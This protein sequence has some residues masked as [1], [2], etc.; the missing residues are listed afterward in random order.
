M[1]GNFKE[2]RWSDGLVWT[3]GV[4]YVTENALFVIAPGFLPAKL[5]WRERR[6]MMSAF[7][8][9]FRWWSKG[10]WSAAMLGD[11]CWMVKRDVPETIPE[12]GQ[13][14]T[15]LRLHIEL[16]LKSPQSTWRVAI[17]ESSDW[18]GTQ[19][20]YDYMLRFIML[21][22]IHFTLGHT[23][24]LPECW[25]VET[26]WCCFNMVDRRQYMWLHAL[27]QFTTLHFVELLAVV[28]LSLPCYSTSGDWNCHIEQCC[29]NVIEE[30]EE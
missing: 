29:F 28:R 2:L 19:I 15:L 13:K 22:S 18:K 8:K 23:C 16:R 6:N 27:L 25:E 9:T 20:Q 7:T 24:P 11:Y 30:D 21:A 3:A 10:K 26:E 17:V 14:E 4:Q 12:T 1:F 5:W